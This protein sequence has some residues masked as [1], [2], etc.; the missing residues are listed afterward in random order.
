M[1]LVSGRV[2]AET[3]LVLVRHGETEWSASGK[4]TGRT[5][6]PLNDI[7]R[8]QAEQVAR[9]LAGEPF[10]AV[11]T[12][13]RSRARDTCRI[14]GLDSDAIVTDDLREWD[15]GVYEGRTTDEIREDEPDWS[16]WTAE[17]RGGESVEDVGRRVD[18]VIEA[19]IAY[20]G[21]VA[22]FGHGHC[23]RILAARWIGLPP[24]AGSLLELSTATVSRL[25]WERER[26]VVELW[27][28]GSHLARD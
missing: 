26:R 5:D 4:H 1:T 19:A 16:V 20:A 15:Y 3:R 23:L 28:D 9:R 7:G 18:R 27:N 22:L 24:A 11:F 2:R 10:A 13:P 12:S 21:D 25:G 17:I 6:I 8:R 14:A